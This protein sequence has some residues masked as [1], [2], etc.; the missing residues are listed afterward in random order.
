MKVSEKKWI[1]IRIHLV[2]VFFLLGLGIVLGRAFQLQ[3]L[4]KGRLAAIAS[5]GYKET[6]TLPPK[7][8]SIYDREG[9]ALAL[10]VEVGS[11]YAHPKRIEDKVKTAN[12]LSHILG[13]RPE[14]ILR[15]LNSD[16]P[17]VWIERRIDPEKAKQVNSLALEGMG[18][19]SET[20]RYYPGREIAAHLIGFA[21]TDNQGLEGVEK[22]YDRLLKGPEYRLIQ[23]RDAMGRPFSISQPIPSGQGMHDVF[24]TID[25]DI[26]YKAQ[27]VLK[28][29]VEKAKARGGQ[30]LVVDPRSGELLALAV[31]PEFNPNIFN[32][33]RA[34][35]WRNRAL[36]DC[37]EP[38]STIKAFLLA[39]SLEEK[40]VT[41]TT[42]FDCEGGKF[43]V[44][45][46]TVHDTHE[47]GVLTV[48]EII[49]LSSNIGAIKIGQKLGYSR[50]YEYLK[51]FGFGR[52]TG[53]DLTGER[54]GFIR[55]P[56]DAKP[57][58]QANLYFGQ[59][60]TTTS[61][62]LAM[63]MA[64][65]ANGGKLMRP[66][67][68][69]KILDESGRIVQE[70]RPEAIRRVISEGTS[71]RVRKIL[72]G[73]V[74][75]E[76]TAARASIEGFR[77]AGK[78]GTSQKVD[79][80]T[81]RYSRSKYVATFV[82]FVPADRPRLVIL[83]MVDEPKGVAYGG[84]IAGPVFREVG[85]WS[86]NYLR[87]N[88]QIRSAESPEFGKPDPKV[89]ALL[90]ARKSEAVR[91]VSCALKAEAGL[92]PDFRGLGMREVLKEGRSLGLKMTVE[93]TG[94]AFRQ[95]PPAGSTLQDV[96]QVKVSFRP[97]T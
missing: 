64:A 50:F 3:V 31:M 19:T 79:P 10:S 76:G 41:P 6:V 91:N 56:K 69:K 32:T 96:T 74:S 8:G 53:I 58:D 95:E 61:L 49:S 54:E 39:A 36:T 20:R 14:T 44:G 2:G 12:R 30:C 46:R 84:L 60:M 52:S 78:T 48:S 38:G 55:S 97:P 73:V 34:E 94:L 11:I 29:A 37:F 45:G 59:G 67:I 27:E 1:R 66:L 87:I 83:V 16:R 18:V 9:H 43:E 26:Q 68:I 7:R 51:R 92:L 4:E 72:E 23:M 70:A 28:S 90:R 63:A 93:G 35:Q 25:K 40:A 47:H 15:L 5:A 65:I 82:G 88:P 81:R 21:G 13:E 42:Q 62:Q 33:Y 86:L 57:I 80:L 85:K 17:F 77:V 22:T 71:D 24:L 89:S 75:E